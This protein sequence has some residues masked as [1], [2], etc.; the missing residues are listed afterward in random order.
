M[1]AP[2]IVSFH[3][4]LACIIVSLSIRLGV[5]EDKMKKW[6]GRS[7]V[8]KHEKKRHSRAA[9]RFCSKVMPALTRGFFP[10]PITVAFNLAFD[11]PD[12]AHRAVYF[13]CWSGRDGGDCR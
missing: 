1:A 4:V 2:S 9:Y 5:V 13:C 11:A 6:M 12:C 7:A 8:L 3:R 10:E